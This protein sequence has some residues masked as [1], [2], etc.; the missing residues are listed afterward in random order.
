[1]KNL[2]KILTSPLVFTQVDYQCRRSIAV[3]MDTNPIV[4]EWAIEQNDLL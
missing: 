2:K 4:I 1:M 3:T